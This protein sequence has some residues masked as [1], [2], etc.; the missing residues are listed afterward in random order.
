MSI[1]FKLSEISP[2]QNTCPNRQESSSG[3]D[4][5]SAS[6]SNN[7]SGGE[8]LG[9]HRYNATHD[10]QNTN[11]EFR[12]FS[13]FLSKHKVRSKDYLLTKSAGFAPF[14]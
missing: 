7:A 1:N 3:N 9:R 4:R 13:V 11:A 14:L 6:Q 12:P 5:I 10:E 8:L 2:D